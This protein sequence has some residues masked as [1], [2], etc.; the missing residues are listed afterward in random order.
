MML[1]EGPTLRLERLEDG[2]AGTFG[3]LVMDGRVC[4]VTLEPPD[5]GNRRDVSCIPVGRYACRGRVSARFGETFEVLDVPGRSDILFHAGNT[6]ADTHGCILLGER[7]G[8]VGGV[9]GIIGSRR[10]VAA[11]RHMLTGV[12]AFT[13]DVAA[14]PGSLGAHMLNNNEQGRS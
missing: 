7:M 6:L 3:V 10:S 9:R 4:G 1:S 8:V 12:I 11:F 14:L 13:L 5:R 2:V